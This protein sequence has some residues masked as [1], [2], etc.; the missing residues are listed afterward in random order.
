MLPSIEPSISH[1][2]LLPALLRAADAQ[3]AEHLALTDP[4]FALAATITLYAHDIEEYGDISRL[5]DFLL[6]Q[7]AVISIYLFAVVCIPHIILCDC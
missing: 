7:E 4:F 3:V 5:Y 2:K 1:L 6:S